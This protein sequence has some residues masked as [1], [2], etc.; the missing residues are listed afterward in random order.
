MALAQLAVRRPIAT[1]MALAAG[2]L[3][4]V[5][6]LLRLEV[7]LL[8]E[9]PDEEIVVWIAD[10]DAAPPEIEQ[11]VARPVED[12]LVSVRGVAGVRSHILP[13]GVSL[14]LRLHPGTDPEIATLGVREKLDALRW[15]LP[16]GVGRPLVQGGTS[17][18]RPAMVL[19]LGAADLEAA[20]DWATT[21]LR[22]RLEQT[23]GVARAA[24]EGAPEREIR[25][26]PDAAR[27]Q[28]A[29]LD[30]E[31][32]AAAL[33]AANAPSPGGTV[34]QRGIRYALHV[35]SE[36]ADPTQIANVIVGGTAA[37]PVRV[38]DVA[39]V[40]DGLA[41]AEGWSRLDGAPAVSVLLHLE[42]G[43]NLVRTS[44][45]VH[46][47]LAEL[48]REFPAFKVAVVQDPAPFV[49][50]SIS[51]LWQAVWMGG[52]LAYGVL[53]YF[54]AD[55]RSPAILM[56]TLPVAVLASFAVLDALGVSLNLLSLGGI[57]MSVGTLV[58]NSII[59]LDSMHRLRARGLGAA[60]AAGEGAREVS[61]PMLASTLTTLSVFVPLAAVPGRFG[62]LFRDQAAAVAVSQV[63]SLI[64]S[65]TLLPMLAARLPLPRRGA[66]RMPLYHAYHRLLVACLRRP[67]VFLTAVLVLLAGSV[68]FLWRAPREILPDVASEDLECEL[69]LPPGS[70]AV[71]TDA[72]VQAIETW[73]RAQPDVER[74]HATIGVA[75]A[76]DLAAAADRAAHHATLRVRLRPGRAA[77][78]RALAA[79]LAA[80][81]A[82]RRDWALEILPSRPEL[83]D[84]FLRG[85]ATLTCEIAGPD[86]ETARELA[87]RVQL[88]A[89]ATF[90]DGAWPLRLQHAELEPRYALDLDRDALW[91][92]GLQSEDVLQALR[93]RTSGLEALRM[94][95]FDS[96]D[97]VVLR[98][99]DL[100]SPSEGTLV[101]AGRTFPMRELFRV[102]TELAPAALERVDQSRVA[103]L[104]WD[105]PL[106]ATRGARAALATAVQAVG[107][108]PGYSV[109][110]GGA[111]A[112]M[113][114]T[115]VGLLRVFA[116]SAGLVFLILAAQFESLRLPLII[117]TD[118]PLALIG[119]AAALALSGGSVN[120]LSVVGM[121]VLNG[122][123]VNDSILK[124][125]LLR[126]LQA[127]GVGRLRAVMVA[128]RRHYRPIWMTTTTA[129]L[130]LVP[131]YF[132]TGSELMAALAT[133]VIGGLWV[134][135]ILT[136]LVVPVVFHAVAG[137]PAR[138]ARA[139]GT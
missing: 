58:D 67:R 107:L 15:Q 22:P 124:V 112:E 121:V 25:V 96:E 83:A 90:T 92:H 68:A 76:L 129:V 99:A 32:L 113:R 11:A 95:R 55:V 130:G 53:L 5:V 1:T 37:A 14:R 42:S 102:R 35:D 31:R 82:P 118:I 50:Q 3:L 41:P 27:L 10:R 91:R 111:D 39:R 136:L 38:R 93:A 86:T 139:G 108:P 137:A 47:R 88:A 62:A 49:R 26:E 87:T 57:A 135:T 117:F 126:R 71:A 2:V 44:R 81:V 63:V 70:D 4:G 60:R 75:G 7:T 69:R 109:R 64:V 59:C 21:V 48:Q 123:V 30:A 36:L 56:A 20:A 46:E 85:A 122:V 138:A 77:A 9:T 16:A 125:D 40:D 29:G 8:P 101:V 132:G 23:E 66:G 119:V 28:A 65:L 106:H 105:G 98:S 131:L 80:H 133:T 79:G 24:I 13:G 74:I 6:S 45:R 114:M 12:A 51:S 17:H 33:Q 127:Q 120:A 19:A 43:A 78:R 61:L 116:L 134:S 72:A 100:R 94:R 73:L 89:A 128:S 97:P 103:I 84:L 115:L 104:R 110:W 34:R 52:L 54:L 18:D